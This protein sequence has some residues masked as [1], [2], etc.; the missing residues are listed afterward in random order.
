MCK[1]RVVRNVC[2]YLCECRALSSVKL[3]SVIKH[4]GHVVLVCRSVCQE[5]TRKSPI[6]ISQEVNRFVPAPWQL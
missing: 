2:A 4:D 3:L 5:E 6:V 1:G